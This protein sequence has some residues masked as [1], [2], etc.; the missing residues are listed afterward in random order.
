[1]KSNNIKA[2][3]NLRYNLLTTFVYII[4]TILIVQLFR[5][6]IIN[7][8]EY[9]ETSNARLTRESVI[10]AAR[11]NIEDRN[12]KIL[13]TTKTGYSVEL[14]KTKNNN[15][16]LNSIILKIVNLLE[17]NN[18]T[19]INNF[20]I[21]SQLKFTYTSEEKINN[22]KMKYNIPQNANEEQCIEVFKEKYE[23]TNTDIKDVLK[24]IAVRYEISTNG[25]SSTKSIKIAEDISKVSAIQFNEQNAEFPGVNII[26]EPIRVYTEGSL[27]SH[28]LGYIRKI[29]GDELKEKANLGYTLNDYIGKM[30][31]EYVLEK[32]LRGEKGTKQIDMSVDGTIEGEYIEQEAISGDTVVLTIDLELQEKMESIIKDSVQQLQKEGNKTEYAAAVLMDVENGE[33]LAMC[34]YPS[35]EPEIFLGTV[36]NDVWQDIEK[37]R[38]LYNNAVQSANA[39]GSTF[40]MVTAAAA[41]E[42]EIVTESEYINDRGVYPYGHNPACWYYNQYGRGHGNVNVKT[43]LQKSCNYFFYEM[44]RRLGVD[45]IAKYAKY[46]GLGEKTGIELAG[47]TAGTVASTA[48]AER[49]GDT[50]Y[51]SNVLSAA[52]GQSYNNF[53]PI[54]MARYISIIANGG[55]YVSPTL[56]KEIK[57]VD[58]NRIPKDEIRKYTNELL[59]VSTNSSSDVS[60]SEETLNTIRAGM[61]LVTSSGGTAYSIFK[62]FDYSVAGKTGSAQAKT[63]EKGE[64][65]NGW[66]VGFTPYENSEV[67]I[68]VFL[69]DGASNSVA[70]K[71]A[72]KILEAYYNTDIL[73]S[74]DLREDMSAQVYAQN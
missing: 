39:P 38:K 70:A 24:I 46:F 14:Y 15:E 26:E 50:W 67:A 44:G 54:Q 48:E 40:K 30:G 13:A 9:R 23:I 20:P 73:E 34:S 35:F 63:K 49:R 16:D 11:G 59:G 1:M 28:I 72:K 69:E 19:Y 36:S 2:N 45:T 53:S 17:A 29:D 10:E 55:N 64:I 62:D 6:Q 5:L 25:Y 71:A 7:G 60:V 3:F 65:T 41:L 66:F 27:A 58:G 32:Y 74:E 8:E 51:P 42:E 57:D 12:E 21:N 61:R 31:I 68:A 33:V 47:E 37:G 52:I 43:A 4:G 18:D 56:I 22:W